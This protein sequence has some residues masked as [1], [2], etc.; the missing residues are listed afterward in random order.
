M[1]KKSFCRGKALDPLDTKI[2]FGTFGGQQK[3]SPQ[4]TPGCTVITTSTT[5]SLF[6]FSEIPLWRKEIIRVVFGAGQFRSTM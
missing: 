1:L 6:D 2:Y 3:L 5:F 4:V